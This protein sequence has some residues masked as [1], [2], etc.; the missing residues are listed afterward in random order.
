LLR[1]L[2]IAGQSVAERSYA[3]KV[4]GFEALAAVRDEPGPKFVFAHILVPHP[5]IV[6]ARDGSFVGPDEA[7]TKGRHLRDQLAWANGRLRAWIEGL[8]SLP[9]DQR[10]IVIL[11][12]DE[13]P[14]PET[15]SRNRMSFDW[16]A[17]T[18]EEIESKF[19]ILNAW[20]LPDGT[21]PGLYDAMTSVNTFPVLF[22]GYYGLP[23]A[24]LEDRSYTSPA[25]RPYEF[26]DVTE[27]LGGSSE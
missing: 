10:P 8:R 25:K 9:E 3:D 13:G 24:K 6:V 26:T 12:A 27:R 1:R 16:S 21:D 22:S 5:P 19:G 20:Y 11:Q 2:G 4:F 7:R 18:P 14:Y 17:A 23:A 15:Y